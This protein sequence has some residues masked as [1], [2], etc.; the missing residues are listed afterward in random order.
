MVCSVCIFSFYIKLMCELGLTIIFSTVG[1]HRE[2][3]HEAYKSIYEHV[4][5]TSF[6]LCSIV[7]V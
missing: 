5:N 6:S 2:P 4:S 7:H 3:S 1:E